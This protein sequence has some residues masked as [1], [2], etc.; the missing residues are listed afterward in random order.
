M[1]LYYSID[2][3][4]VQRKMKDRTDGKTMRIES[5]NKKGSGR[6]REGG[7][8]GDSSEEERR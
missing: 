6:K 7:R 5:E 8:E 1:S 2:E 3:K 4:D